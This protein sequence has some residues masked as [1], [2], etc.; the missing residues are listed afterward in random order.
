VVQIAEGADWR[1]IPPESVGSWDVYLCEDPAT[2]VAELM[3]YQPYDLVVVDHVHLM[4]FDDRREIER[5]IAAMKR[6]SIDHNVPVLLL[7]Q[8]R[9][10]PDFHRPRMNQFRETRMFEANSDMVAMVWRERDDQGQPSELAELLIR[11]DRYGEPRI[12]ELMF[13]GRWTRFVQRP[14]TRRQYEPDAYTQ[15]HSQEDAMWEYEMGG[16]R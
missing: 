12:E 11:K 7:G 15:S 2:Q 10:D 8:L 4:G 5:I 1:S 13:E 3:R 14:T 16:G 6:L 9:D